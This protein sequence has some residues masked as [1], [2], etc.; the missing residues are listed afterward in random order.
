M[1][2]IM[3]SELFYERELINASFTIMSA[4]SLISAITNY[5]NDHFQMN[6]C[7]MLLKYKNV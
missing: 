1:I 5:F 7:M 4:R 2:E 3:T 6:F